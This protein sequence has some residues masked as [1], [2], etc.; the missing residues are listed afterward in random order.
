[1]TLLKNFIELYDDCI[2]DK[3]L[4]N[5]YYSVL[6]NIKFLTNYM[7]KDCISLRGVNLN[8]YYT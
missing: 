3:K 5:D 1:M 6:E 4:I 7:F 2:K 8:E